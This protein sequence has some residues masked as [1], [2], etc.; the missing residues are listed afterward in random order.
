MATQSHNNYTITN[1]TYS[2]AGGA[3]VALAHSNA[4]LTI[5]PNPGYSV[6]AEDFT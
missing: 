1:V 2:V 4:V 5:T 6:T 3:N